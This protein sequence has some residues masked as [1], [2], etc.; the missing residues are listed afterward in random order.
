MS[1]EFE[2]LSSESKRRGSPVVR[3]THPENPGG[4]VDRLR[5]AETILGRLD[6]L[7]QDPQRDRMPCLLLNAAIG[8][9][10]T[11]LP[12]K[13]RRTHPPFFDSTVGVQQMRIVAMQAARAG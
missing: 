9:G 1:N 10:K 11:K 8:M 5:A 12:R 6:E 3:E 2:H 4:T 13:F 7:L